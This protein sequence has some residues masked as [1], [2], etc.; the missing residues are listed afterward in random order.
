[1]LNNYSEN[2]TKMQYKEAS[3]C[4]TGSSFILNFFYPLLEVSSDG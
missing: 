1:M 2:N 3:N 4:L